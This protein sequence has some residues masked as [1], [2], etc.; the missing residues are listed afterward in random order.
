M[1][2]FGAIEVVPKDPC[3]LRQYEDLTALWTEVGGSSFKH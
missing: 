1:R 3:S 2:I